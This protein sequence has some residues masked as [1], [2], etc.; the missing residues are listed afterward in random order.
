MKKTLALLLASGA[1]LGACGTTEETEAPEESIEETVAEA[2]PDEVEA[3]EEQSDETSEELAEEVTDGAQ[4]D[5][6]YYD[7]YFSANY[8]QSDNEFENQLEDTTDLA[9]FYSVTLTDEHE[10]GGALPQKTFIDI[11]EDGR[12][13]MLR[14]D[15][16]DPV[17]DAD[18]DSVHDANL[19]VYLDAIGEPSSDESDEVW[20]EYTSKRTANDGIQRSGA[21]FMYIDEQ[22]DLRKISQL[23]PQ[24]IGM[25]SGY[26]VQEYGETQ[27]RTVE[28]AR[29][30]S[31][32]NEKGEIALSSLLNPVLDFIRAGELHHQEIYMSTFNSQFGMPLDT[33]TLSKVNIDDVKLPF[34]IDSGHLM[35]VAQ[36]SSVLSHDNNERVQKKLQLD[37]YQNDPDLVYIE[38]NN[39]LLQYLHLTDKADMRLADDPSEFKGYTQDN[40]EIVPD[41]VF[42][43]P[44]NEGYSPRT[45]H[46]DGTILEYN[47]E[48]GTWD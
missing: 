17:Y 30:R 44:G 39:E 1:L 38:N 18:I 40:T 42:V 35:S 5:D 36:V 12:A 28:E 9:G 45:L 47:E 41:V 4:E 43:N 29:V 26:L 15:V 13:T 48:N 25:A 31:H 8:H 10:T 46:E 24:N 23:S 32:Y 14:Y 20:A 21:F 33:V 16:V 7:P 27:F 37:V 6:D 34:L 11:K 2:A 19:K 3:P 22:N